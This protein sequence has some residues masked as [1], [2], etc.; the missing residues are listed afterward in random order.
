M[1]NNMKMVDALGKNTN[2]KNQAK[3]IQ[4]IFEAA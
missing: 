1:T 2:I 3:D 4:K